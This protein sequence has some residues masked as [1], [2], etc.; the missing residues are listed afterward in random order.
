V[1]EKGSGK[2]KGRFGK[3]TYSSE[4]N[5]LKFDVGKLWG[6]GGGGVFVG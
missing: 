5:L 1:C 3:R 6:G 2:M 4:K